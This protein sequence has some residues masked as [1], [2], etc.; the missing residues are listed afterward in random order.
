MDVWSTFANEEQ[1]KNFVMALLHIGKGRV[2][3]DAKNPHIP[4][5][6]D[7]SVSVEESR[8][9]DL[10]DITDGLLKNLDFY[11]LEVSFELISTSKSFDHGIRCCMMS[12]HDL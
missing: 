6:G 10:E 7:C 1:L 9:E 4:E 3:D 11:E 5:E 2:L 8:D 12:M